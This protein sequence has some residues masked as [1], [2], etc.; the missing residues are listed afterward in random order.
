MKALWHIK[1][2]F[3]WGLGLWASLG[4]WWLISQISLKYLPS[5]ILEIIT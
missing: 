3:F 1:H 4:V 5:T 2:G